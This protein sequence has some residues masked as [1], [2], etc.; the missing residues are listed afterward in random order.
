MNLLKQNSP[1]LEHRLG[2][3]C[4]SAN[5]DNVLINQN[6]LFSNSSEDYWKNI[7]VPIRKNTKKI[8]P[9]NC[10]FNN[11]FLNLLKF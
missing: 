1:L 4:F 11:N 8:Y 6:K 10:N 5:E 2:N 9:V 3:F 7:E